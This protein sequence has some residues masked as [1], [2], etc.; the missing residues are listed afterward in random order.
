MFKDFHIA[1]CL[2]CVWD[3]EK[4]CYRRCLNVFTVDSKQC[5]SHLCP[6]W[7]DGCNRIYQMMNDGKDVTWGMTKNPY[8]SE[9]TSTS[10]GTEEQDEFDANYEKYIAQGMDPGTA[11]AKLEEDQK[12]LAE[13]QKMEE[14]VAREKIPRLQGGRGSAY[15][16]AT[17]ELVVDTPKSGKLR[18]LDVKSR[19]NPN[20]RGTKA[21]LPTVTEEDE[22]VKPEKE[23]GFILKKIWG[24]K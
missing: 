12:E 6:E 18:M 11:F 4:Q 23:K 7:K 13:K 15:N 24:R 5:T 8:V 14:E 9:K 22:N 17:G 21:G 10:R 19:R 2:N 3:E 1:C 16:M 20:Q